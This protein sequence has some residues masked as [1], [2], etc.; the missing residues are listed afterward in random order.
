MT[1]VVS[2]A[3]SAARKRP[4]TPGHQPRAVEDETVQSAGGPASPEPGD[5]DGSAVHADAVLA[6][7]GAQALT[8]LPKELTVVS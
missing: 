5:P 7:V 1:A 3:N 2:A 4:R 8:G 6:D